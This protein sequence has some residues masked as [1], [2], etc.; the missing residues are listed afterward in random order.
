MNKVNPRGYLG[1]QDWLWWAL[2]IHERLERVGL[3]PARASRQPVRARQTLDG[4][5]RRHVAARRPNL[6]PNT[7]RNLEQAGNKLVEHFGKDR[8]VTDITQG[9]AMD[10]REKLLAGMAE[11]AAATHIAKAKQFFSYALAHKIIAEDPFAAVTKGSQTNRQRLRF[12]TREEIAKLLAVCPDNEWRLIVVLARYGGLRTPS[13]MQELKWTDVL[14]DQNKILIT[15]QKKQHLDGHATRF[16][17]IFPEIRPYLQAAWD[18]AEEGAR[19]V[20]PR[21]T[22]PGVNLNTQM[23]R[24][25]AQA[26]LAAWPRTFQNLR[27][28][29]DTEL[30]NEYPLYLVNA[31]IGHTSRVAQDHYQMVTDEDFLRAGQMPGRETLPTRESVPVQ[32]P[33][34]TGAIRGSQERSEANTKAVSPGFPNEMAFSIPSTGI[35]GSLSFPRKTVVFEGLVPKSYPVSAQAVALGGDPLGNETA[36]AAVEDENRSEAKGRRSN[37]R[38]RVATS[39]KAGGHPVIVG[40]TRPPPPHKSAIRR[41]SGRSSTPRG[42]RHRCGP[43]DASSAAR[44]SGPV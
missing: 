27:A 12:V 25:I 11:A 7:V 19:F 44:R 23:R 13:E 20:V 9:D 33:V 28:S 21:A 5:I 22:R 41:A 10:W 36:T 35:S 40:T 30:A 18:E 14:W 1:R 15:V 32:I 39:P 6:K 43:S 38:S 42:R 24:L 29:R 3:V 4:L 31:W 17:P 26:G 8:P 16:V 34:Q 37:T 2:T